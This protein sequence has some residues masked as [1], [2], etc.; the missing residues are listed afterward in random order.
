MAL[1]GYC[2]NI[3]LARY[4]DMG[5]YKTIT[6]TPSYSSSESYYIY[7]L[8]SNDGTTWNLITS[9]VI[10]TDDGVT[11][12]PTHY[13]IDLNS[14]LITF[15]ALYHPIAGSIIVAIYWL[16]QGFTDDD[17]T[18]FVDLGAVQLEEDTHRVFRE[19]T[20][21]SYKTDAN[22]DYTY[23]YP[24][25]IDRWDVLNGI[26]NINYRTDSILSLE[27]GPILSVTTLTVD[28]T[29]VTPSTLKLFGN[30]IMLTEDSEVRSFT[31]SHDSI[32]ITYKYGIISTVASRTE[33]DLRLIE[34]AKQANILASFLQ[35]NSVLK[36][37][38]IILDNLYVVQKSDGSIRPE[39][40]LDNWVIQ[41]QRK[42]DSL[43]KKLRL[44]G[45]ST[46]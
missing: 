30:K 35:I 38:N 11:I 19:I 31:K 40:V 22:G 39:Q 29:S 28:G 41:V 46:I 34:L 43:L 15:G 3:D 21:T 9:G 18:Y 32:T 25:F 27:Y 17:L 10:L 33:E 45:I 6:V 36:G 23:V 4:L 13:T 12:D 2:E 5:V 44:N 1:S 42:Y 37:R 8:T 7:P 14:G 20:V 16:N 24:D 26:D